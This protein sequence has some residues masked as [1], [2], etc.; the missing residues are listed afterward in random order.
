M[1]VYNV[2]VPGKHPFHVDVTKFGTHRS[3]SIVTNVLQ[4][5]GKPEEFQRQR[6][7]LEVSGTNSM[8][9]GLENTTGFMMCV[10]GRLAWFAK[11][12]FPPETC[13]PAK[14]LAVQ[15]RMVPHTF[16]H[17][18][19]PCQLI[20]IHTLMSTWRQ[21]EKEFLLAISKTIILPMFYGLWRSKHAFFQSFFLILA[22]AMEDIKQQKGTGLRQSHVPASHLF[23]AV[24][25]ATSSGYK[26]I[27]LL[28][29]SYICWIELLLLVHLCLS[30]WEGSHELDR[31]LFSPS[32]TW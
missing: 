3:V 4:W 24:A 12:S 5:G 8:H 27:S 14:S 30:C 25:N 7:T 16:A 11:H 18:Q 6:L 28:T 32:A 13:G 29:Y 23:H 21:E 9:S 31:S 20:F 1:L 26:M 2:S 22:A 10:L 15:S 19:I 17:T